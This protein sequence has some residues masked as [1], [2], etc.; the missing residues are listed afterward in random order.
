MRTTTIER[1]GEETELYEFVEDYNLVAEQANNALRELR[2]DLHTWLPSDIYNQMKISL[3]TYNDIRVNA[4]CHYEHGNN[5]IAL[6][7]GLMDA[8]WKEAQDFVG[9]ERLSLVIKVDEENK[10]H[11]KEMLYFFMLN[12]TIAH[13]L[14]HIAH[15]HLREQSGE[16]SIDEMFQELSAIPAGLDWKFKETSNEV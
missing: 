6:S 3:W 12:F 1:L 9:Q 16:N 2:K 7:L 13:E 4:F 5:Y 11:L 8:F 14:G 10:Q 15:G